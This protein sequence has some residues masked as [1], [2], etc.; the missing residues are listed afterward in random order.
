MNRNNLNIWTIFK[1]RATSLTKMAKVDSSS[2]DLSETL[3]GKSIKIPRLTSLNLYSWRTFRSS[4][5]YC[6]TL[7]NNW[8]TSTKTLPLIPKF[9]NQVYLVS[10][11]A[12]KPLMSEDHW[13]KALILPCV[14][15]KISMRFLQ[16]MSSFNKKWKNWS[17]NFHSQSQTGLSQ[18]IWH[19]LGGCH[20][21]P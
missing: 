8:T 3:F 9:P 17:F 15:S 1:E 20:D 2:K 6:S 12:S 19:Q 4:W 5:K 11:P 10:I 18:D 16:G 13:P 7:S 21:A 14:L